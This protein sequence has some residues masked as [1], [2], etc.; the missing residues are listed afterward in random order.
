MDS[1]LVAKRAARPVAEKAPAPS[2]YKGSPWGDS[3]LAGPGE[4]GDEVAE[5]APA[6]RLS[7]DEVR[8]KVLGL[9]WIPLQHRHAVLRNLGIELSGSAE[10]AAPAAPPDWKSLAQQFRDNEA[11]NVWTGTAVAK[12]IEQF[13]AARA[14]SPL[15]ADE[16][17][18][19]CAELVDTTEGA[20]VDEMVREQI[21]ALKGRFTLA[22]PQVRA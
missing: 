15:S 17:V 14:A 18:E 4:S 13:E 3:D 1:E 5:K 10:K 8:S 2:G 22:A 6:S 12:A 21:R 19:A 9:S 11:T 7:E 16:I 20:A